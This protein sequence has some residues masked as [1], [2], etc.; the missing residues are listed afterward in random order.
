MSTVAPQTFSSDIQLAL[1][2]AVVEANNAFSQ[3]ANNVPKKKKK[4]RVREETEGT[5]EATADEAQPKEKKRKKKHRASES[6]S[7]DIEQPDPTAE[8]PQADSATPVEAPRKKSKKKDKGKKPEEGAV[9]EEVNTTQDAATQP[10]NATE[11]DI[12]AST[13]A[14]LSAIVAA[15]AGTPDANL[16]PSA[17]PPQDVPQP[18]PNDGS[19]FMG[20]APPFGFPGM[21]LMQAPQPAQGMP[22][23]E[24]TFG[25]NEDVLRAI[26]DLD[27]SKLANVLKTIGE[28]S[29]ETSAG[30]SG[31]LHAG[32]SLPARSQ[33]MGTKK[34]SKHVIA[35]ASQAVAHN[36]HP[37]HAHMLANKWLSA[38]KLADLVKSEGLVYKKGKFSA[39]EEQQLKEAIDL[40]RSQHGMSEDD[41]QELI[42]GKKSKDSTFWMEITAAVPQ[43]PIIAVY[44]H[45]R[46]HFHPMAQKGKWLPSEDA[47]LKQAVVDL[48]QQWEKVSLRVGRMSS[49]CRDRWRNH[50]VN[51]EI[52]VS[53]TWTQEEEQKLTEIVTEMTIQQG[54]D[55]DN[56]VFW[57]KV[58][59]RMGGTRGRQQCRIK[60][61]DA[62][63]K[64]LKN[65]G[66][67]PRWSHLDA[68]I[69]VHK[70]DSLNVRDDTEID[71]KT[72][73]DTNWNLWSAHTLQRRWLTMK[74]GIKG[75][76]DMTHQEIMDILR[77]KKA[78]IPTITPTATRKR[79][80]RKVTSSEA[81][82]ELEQSQDGASDDGDS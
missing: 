36:T 80:D 29:G 78:Q 73:P 6:A 74:R 39:I 35:A 52:R 27:V 50:I 28:A 67:C 55:V 47:L 25:S 44:H 34:A 75:H 56:D 42:F 30:P 4:K 70:V 82:E 45:V 43:R 19:G 61:T 17:P 63:S 59:E 22:F 9:A 18:F 48:G 66:Q 64:T 38:T 57:G 7:N 37:D 24:L 32:L 13:A 62:L 26:Q 11:E 68:F 15:A 53:G 2:H 1:Q 3:N 20:Y 60:W 76:E 21:Q 71:W 5:T 79:K 41:L 14:L 31:G 54:R 33:R 16:A 81:I 46:R 72:L 23:S 8:E 49:D 12:Q 40:Y 51:R 65:D 58:S 77:V 10:D 69:L